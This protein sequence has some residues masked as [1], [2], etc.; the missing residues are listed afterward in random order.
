MEQENGGQALLRLVGLLAPLSHHV[1]IVAQLSKRRVT[2]GVEHY[3]SL[4]LPCARKTRVGKEPA[5]ASNEQPRGSSP[6]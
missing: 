3:S 6:A 2:R 5:P 4:A 1:Q